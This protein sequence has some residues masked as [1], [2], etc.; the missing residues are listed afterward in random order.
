MGELGLVHST[1]RSFFPNTFVVRQFKLIKVSVSC[2][3]RAIIIRNGEV[4]PMSTEFTPESERQR[5]QFLV[6]FIG[7]FFFPPENKW[8]H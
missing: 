3:P 7:F 1:Q 4:I 6:S 2:L 8:R 5:L